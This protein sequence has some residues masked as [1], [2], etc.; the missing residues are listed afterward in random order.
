MASKTIQI[1]LTNVEVSELLGLTMHQGYPVLIKIMNAA[2]QRAVKDVLEAE[3]T[4]AAKIV[5]AQN[6]ARASKDFYDRVCNTVDWI[7]TE[8]LYAKQHPE[9]EAEL[10]QA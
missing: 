1:E 4:E 5:A 6:I 7:V 2:Y 3:P 10:N 9:L 8:G